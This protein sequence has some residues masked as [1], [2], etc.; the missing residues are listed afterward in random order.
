MGAAAVVARPVSRLRGTRV[1]V[2]RR[3]GGLAFLRA[4]AA[5]VARRASP[6][7]DLLG[8]QPLGPRV[9]GGR[10]PAA[11][12]HERR[13]GVRPP[14]RQGA[15]VVGRM[16]GARGD[17]LSPHSICV[18][19][20]AHVVWLL[21]ISLTVVQLRGGERRSA[22]A[23]RRRA[24]LPS[25]L[26][27]ALATPDQPRD[28]APMVQWFAEQVLCVLGLWSD[29]ACTY[30]LSGERARPTSDRR[31][32]R[33]GAPAPSISGC[34]M[35]ASANACEVWFDRSR[36]FARDPLGM[37]TIFAIAR[38]S[39]DAMM[40]SEAALIR[41]VAPMANTSLATHGGRRREDAAD[42]SAN[43]TNRRRA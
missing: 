4:G 36:A 22:L 38:G 10:R 26:I 11:G 24:G 40:A 32:R 41:R 21:V 43:G 14:A 33:T 29:V 13:A 12:E 1:A 27:D 9:L 37:V 5:M 18:V 16:G 2:G 19:S 28:A 3:L 25:L 17:P 7:G 42:P 30:L 20:L 34:P 15:R 6:A 23:R 35:C 31:G 39:E 8:A